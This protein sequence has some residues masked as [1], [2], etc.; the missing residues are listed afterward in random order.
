LSGENVCHLGAGIETESFSRDEE[1]SVI[2]PIPNGKIF[3]FSANATVTQMFRFFNPKIRFT[4]Q[5]EIFGSPNVHLPPVF[6]FQKS[7]TYNFKVCNP[8]SSRYGVT[9]TALLN[10]D[11]KTKGLTFRRRES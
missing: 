9:K 11:M 5:K 4:P 8:S 6:V 3:H 10:E 1:F 2:I 7:C